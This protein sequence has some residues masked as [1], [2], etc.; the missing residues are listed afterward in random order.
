VT[1]EQAQSEMNTL[2]AQ[3]E[4]EFPATNQGVQLRLTPLRDA[5]VGN[6]RPTSGCCLA[7]S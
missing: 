3:L 2:A 4:R 1:L 5:E 7:R 6:V